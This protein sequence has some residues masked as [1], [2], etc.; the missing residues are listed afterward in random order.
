LGGL[1]YRRV[2]VAEMLGLDRRGGTPEELR[3]LSRQWIETANGLRAG[4]EEDAAGAMRLRAG[5]RAAHDGLQRAGARLP[6]LSGPR[7]RPKGALVSPLLARMGITGIFVPF[8][9]EAH[10]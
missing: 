4:V 9:G 8:T 3:A 1:N 5:R 2:P 7:V 10:V 6:A